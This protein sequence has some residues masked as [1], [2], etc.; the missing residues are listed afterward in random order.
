MEENFGIKLKFWRKKL[1][2]SQNKLASKS[3]VSPVTIGQI[4]TG[5]RKARMSTQQKLVEGL[6]LTMSQFQGVIK[7]SVPEP[8]AIP[9]EKPIVYE[10]PAPPPPPPPAT[11]KEITIVLSNLDLEIINRTLNLTFDAKLDVLRYINSIK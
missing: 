4:E 8:P 7:Q 1:G 11:V 9:M 3:G 2:F 5:K 6:D 10:K